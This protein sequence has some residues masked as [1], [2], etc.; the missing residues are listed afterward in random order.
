MEVKSQEKFLF[1]VELWEDV[2]GFC[3]RNKF[4]VWLLFVLA[5][6]RVCI[7]GTAIRRYT[8]EQYPN[9]GV[10]KVLNASNWL[11]ELLTE[12]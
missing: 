2:Y 11:D 7:L 4:A 6:K 1:L 3:G 5:I 9:L 10:N 12:V 8:T